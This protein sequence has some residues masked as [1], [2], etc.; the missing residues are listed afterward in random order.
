MYKISKIKT[1]VEI[2]TRYNLEVFI[3]TVLFGQFIGI[4][5]QIEKR[6]KQNRMIKAVNKWRIRHAEFIRLPI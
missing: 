6:K 5:G 3:C 4:I 2:Y 1:C